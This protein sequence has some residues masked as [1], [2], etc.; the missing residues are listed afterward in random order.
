MEEG[1]SVLSPLAEAQHLALEYMRQKSLTDDAPADIAREYCA[2]R[3]QMYAALHAVNG[4]G[5]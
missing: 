5:S 1:K 2:I 3:Q 4:T